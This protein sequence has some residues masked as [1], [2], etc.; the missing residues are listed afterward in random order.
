MNETFPF[1]FNKHGKQTN[2]NIL[3]L[4]SSFYSTFIMELLQF[5]ASFIKL[6]LKQNNKIL[7]TNK[8]LKIIPN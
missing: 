2:S 1:K 5:I 3:L 6:A 4:H 8:R 7:L